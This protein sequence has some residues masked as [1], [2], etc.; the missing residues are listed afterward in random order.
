LGRDIPDA[1][2]IKLL[3]KPISML[4]GNGIDGSPK[5]ALRTGR[6]DYRLIDKPSDSGA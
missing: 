2:L 1:E 5:A 3:K 6:G 4:G